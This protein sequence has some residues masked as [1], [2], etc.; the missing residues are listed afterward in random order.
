MF[1]RVSA[2]KAPEKCTNLTKLSQIRQPQTQSSLSSAK[3]RTSPLS[4]MRPRITK[5]SLQS[6]NGLACQHRTMLA[7]RASL[8]KP[9]KRR[10]DARTRRISTATNCW[11]TRS[12]SSRGRSTCRMSTSRTAAK[13][14]PTAVELS[15][16]ESTMKKARRLRKINRNGGASTRPRSWKPRTTSC[17]SKTARVSSWSG[18]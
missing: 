14:C 15:Y 8:T 1:Q 5:N 2:R 6:P 4:L 7:M 9:R 12:R 3:K 11:R 16:S 18:K 17:S 13:S 10:S